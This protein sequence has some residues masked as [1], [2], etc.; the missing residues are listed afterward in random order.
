M[1]AP[2]VAAG[3]ALGLAAVGGVATGYAIDKTLG[4]GNY[5]RREAAT[6]AVLGTIPGIG[7]VKPIGKITYKSTKLRHFSRA[8]GDNFRDIPFV[9]AAIT[10]P[11]QK[12]IA[13]TIATERGVNYIA[14]HLIAESRRSSS[15][16]F[17]QNGGRRGKPKVSE[18][19]KVS[20]DRKKGSKKWIPSCRPGFR[21]RR[22]GKKLM[23]VK[24]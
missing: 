18:T 22:I 3:L 8:Q 20:W 1:V 6:D 12:V 9:M 15:T 4:D 11:E 19:A 23:C 13:K 2:L 21:L 16:S 24:N 7:F 10:V 5:T 17:Q 14:S